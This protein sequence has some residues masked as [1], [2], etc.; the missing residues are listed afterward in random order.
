MQEN[1][2]ITRRN[3]VVLALVA[4]VL[5]VVALSLAIKYFVDNSSRVAVKNT[6]DINGLIDDNDYQKMKTSLHKLLED[7]Y[8]I[9]KDTVVDATIR[10]SSYNDRTN[11]NEGA[12]SF[13]LDIDSLK[14]TYNVSIIHSSS[15]HFDISFGCPK[16]S[17]S[18]YPETFCIATDNHSTI[19]AE[20]DNKLPYRGY[21]DG[22]STYVIRHNVNVPKLT[23]EI[24]TLCGDTAARERALKDALTWIDGTGISSEFIPYEAPEKFCS[25]V[26]VTKIGS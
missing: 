9:S 1:Q 16:L 2:N 6:R 18:K 23:I 10:E 13:L 14:L 5:L 25:D 26:D 4:F 15:S 3:L 17:A 11:G 22:I 20:L 12:I 8:G 19:D 21:I 24:Y 7:K